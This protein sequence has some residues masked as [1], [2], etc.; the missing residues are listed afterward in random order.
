[1]TEY[2]SKHGTVNRPQ[3]ELYMA[4]TDL[5][6]F[7]QFLPE[8]RKQDVTAGYDTLSARVQGISIGV[9]VVRREPYSYIELKDDGAPFSFNVML[10]FDAV[11]GD[12]GSTDFYIVVDADLNFMMKMM[13]GGKLQEAL[14]RVVDSL[15]DVS[16]GKIPDGIP[17]DIKSGLHF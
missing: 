7:L 6:N 14:D 8:D 17:E 13:I 9:R 15:V 2:K 4:F 3:A 1:M 5:R 10:H 12:A 16:H 11:P